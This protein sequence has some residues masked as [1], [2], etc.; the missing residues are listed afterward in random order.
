MIVPRLIERKRDGGQLSADEWTELINAYAQNHIPDY[1]MSAL[2]MACYFSGLSTSEMTALTEAML[3]SGSRFDLSHLKQARI[4]KHS[5]GGV[6]DKTSLILAPLISCL[7]I[8]VPMISGRG[9]GHTGGTLDKLESIPGFRTGLSIKDSIAQ[10]DRIGCAMVGQT[11]EIAPADKKIYAL[12]DATSTVEVVQLIAASIMSKKLAESLTGLVLD[13]K[14]GSGSFLPDLER[15]LVLAQAMIALGVAHECPVVALIT[16]MD[17]PLGYACGNSIEVAECIDAMHGTGPDDLM[18]V[19]YALGAEMLILGGVA[20]N[21]ETA[22]AMMRDAISS[23]KA[24][25]KFEEIIHAQHGDARVVSDTDRLPQAKLQSAFKASRSGYITRVEPRTIGHGIIALGGGRTTMEDIVDPSVGFFI[26]AKP[27]MEV[28]AG[29]V[30]A[31]VFACDQ[32]GA[33]TGLSVLEK[34]ISIGDVPEEYL[35]LISHRIT[36][37]GTQVLPA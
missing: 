24:A 8:A 11:A 36:S 14:G 9:L 21:H 4:D 1:Q 34:A 31:T 28:R 18:V 13:V 16:A 6:G 7:G 25:A 15:E 37:E 32:G 26:T 33:D 2:L 5:M 35:P 17:R 20:D 29:E 12:R 30:I 10:I 19:T 23:G 22:H 27:G 3:L